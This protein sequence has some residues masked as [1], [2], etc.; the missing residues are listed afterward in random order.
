LGHD[1]GHPRKGYVPGYFEGPIP[2][3]TE[4]E[5]LTKYEQNCRFIDELY[6]KKYSDEEVA[7]VLGENFLRVMREVLPD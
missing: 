5:D 1:I 2:G 3:H 7:K 4:I 6:K